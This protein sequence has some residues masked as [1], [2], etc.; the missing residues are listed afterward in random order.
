MSNLVSYIA[1]VLAVGIPLIITAI[2]GLFAERSGVT[3]IALEGLMIIGAFVGILFMNNVSAK[4]VGGPFVLFLI[5][6]LIVALIGVLFSMIH[7]VASIKMNAD[8]IIS[9]TAINTLTPALALFLTMSLSLGAAAGSD[10]LPVHGDIFKISEVPVLSKIPILGDIFFKNINASFYMGIII[11]VVSIVFLYKTRFGLRLRACGENPHA[12]DAAGINIQ[13]V[14]FIAVGISG[15]L[16]ALGGFY[17]V[18]AYTTEF[19]ASVSGYGFLA[20]AV[21]IFGNWKPVRVAISAI[22]FAAL[23]TLSR[24][25]A[26]F[27]A[28]ESL[29]IDK[30]ILSMIP[31]I[32]T[33]IVL[34]ISSKNN[35]APKAVGKVYDKGER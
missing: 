12:A 4:S 17:L 30:N 25:I 15:A 2:G 21:L 6:S 5:T 26:F 23:L 9:A 34:V 13:R 16:A 33:L 19:S 11:L 18:T 14:R 7:A 20:V 3:N 1:L 32:A 24:G 10:K 22:F 35:R 29:N 31:Y 8:Q 27:P 28:L